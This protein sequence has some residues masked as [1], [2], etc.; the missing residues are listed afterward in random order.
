MRLLMLIPMIFALLWTSPAKADTITIAKSIGFVEDSG[1]SPEV[2]AEC[3]MQTRLPGYIKKEGKRKVDIEL[4]EGPLEDAE[5]KVLYLEITNVFAP[6]G[7]PQPESS[8]LMRFCLGRDSIHPGNQ[9]L[10]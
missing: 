2:I 8:K 7:S 3:E 1:A 4:S 6:G 10:R 9:K 5:G